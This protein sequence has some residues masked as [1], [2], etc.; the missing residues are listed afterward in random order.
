MINHFLR[1]EE[2][3]GE[4]VEVGAKE[5]EPAGTDLGGGPGVDIGG[6]GERAGVP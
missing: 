1:P 5:E 4:G 3:P 2:T 6:V